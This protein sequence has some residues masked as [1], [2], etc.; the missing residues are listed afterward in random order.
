MMSGWFSGHPVANAVT[1]SAEVDRFVME[2]SF[3]S[4]QARFPILRITPRIA[5][6]AL[7]CQA[8]GTNAVTSISTFAR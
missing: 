4:E 3:M 1:K 6:N 5:P 2:K 7:S 8:A